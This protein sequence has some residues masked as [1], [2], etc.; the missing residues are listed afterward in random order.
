VLNYKERKKRFFEEIEDLNDLYKITKEILSKKPLKIKYDVEE[1]DIS[2][3]AFDDTTKTFN[4]STR[5][6]F[7]PGKDKI[8]IGS[9]LHD[10]YYEAEFEVLDTPT[11]GLFR[12]KLHGGRK[13][14]TGRAD[15][16]FKIKP[17]EAYATNFRVSKHTIDISMFKLPTSIKVIL[18]QFVVQSKSRYDFC[19][20]GYF[21]QSDTILNQMKKTGNS[22][23]VEN[24]SDIDGHIP[25][26]D[27][28]IKI[29][30]LMKGEFA[31]YITANREKGYKSIMMVPVIYITPNEQSI[32][33]AYIK[34]MSK[35]KEL[36]LDDFI[37][38]KE[39][40]FNLINRIRDANTQYIDKRQEIADISR[41]GA[42]LK[43][44]DPELKKYLAKAR[45]FI[46]D[47][48]FKLQQP[49][50]MYGEVRFTG[51]NDNN[52]LMLG[53][54]FAG[55]TSRK[56]QMQ[57]LYAILK[58]MEISYKKRLIEQIKKKQQM[59]SELS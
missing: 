35:E 44:E 22:F 11:A 46:F 16:R 18:D 7:I 33:F 53:L 50:T 14:T 6:D 29:S 19:E 37:K 9:A 47:I 58:P 12:C 40:T 34:V 20:V 49:I 42:R 2:L 52:D 39:Q 10:K 27:D 56:N 48:V 8:I 17:G 4:G 15:I 36:M 26:S 1:R 57:H 38:L 45:G 23:L 51:V 5:Q 25:M 32:P 30:D 54:S 13:A 55:N 31:S 43:I 28:F 24:L 59:Q 41:G 21:D 3:S